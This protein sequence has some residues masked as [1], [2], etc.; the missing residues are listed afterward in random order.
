MLMQPIYISE[1]LEMHYNNEV[2]WPLGQLLSENAI[3]VER[4]KAYWY[5]YIPRAMMASS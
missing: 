2:C 1:R 3:E 5:W 4:A